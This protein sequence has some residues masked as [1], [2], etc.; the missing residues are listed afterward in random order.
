MPHDST[1][2]FC[3]RCG[4]HTSAV[5]CDDD[6]TATLLVGAPPSAPDR[7][8]PGHIVGGRYRIV[9]R[10]GHGGFGAVFDAEHVGTGQSMA[11]KV[12]AGQSDESDVRRF[13]REARITARLRH[14]N[15]VRVFD[16]GQDDDGTVYIAMEKLVGQPLDVAISARIRAGRTFSAHEIIHFGAEIAVS[17][18]E[19]HEAG[20]VHRDLKP[21]NAFLVDA[22]RGE[23]PRC[24]VLDFGIARHIEHSITGNA[25]RGTATH[26]SPEQVRSDTLDGRSDQYALGVILYQLAARRLPH[27]G[28]TPLQ[29]LY[30]QVDRAPEPLRE[31]VGDQY[32]AR[33]LDA[34]HKALAKDRDERFDS[35][36]RM[37]AELRAC[38]AALAREESD[39]Y[40]AHADTAAFAATQFELAEPDHV[41][42]HAETQA[43]DSPV[44][45]DQT[46]SPRAGRL[47]AASWAALVVAV[48]F[49][50]FAAVTSLGPSEA[51]TVDLAPN[52]AP[53][54]AVTPATAALAAPVVKKVGVSDRS[55]HD[56]SAPDAAEPP[57]AGSSKEGSDVQLARPPY[58]RTDSS[59][60]QG[61]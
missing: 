46:L 49:F 11:V 22:G 18:H 60:G 4:A 59:A 41:D 40:T 23:L 9:G 44:T 54:R 16:F 6:A 5:F 53:S 27:R 15:T 51:P 39:D 21:A 26:M 37:A 42:V 47:A 38:G 36:A 7:I 56:R 34:I 29:T 58:S 8:E 20:L 52:Q 1:T 28:D 35:A 43:H 45:A 48:V 32:P 33:L 17:L 2:R 30:Q 50:A 24:K 14:P 31:L 61:R 57:D 10:L 12:L 3:P 55:A 25:L 19:A 13:Y